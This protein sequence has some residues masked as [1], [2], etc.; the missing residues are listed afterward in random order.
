MVQEQTL[1]AAVF[2]VVLFLAY[3]STGGGDI[4]FETLGICFELHGVTAQK[5]IFFIVPAV[6]TSDP[7]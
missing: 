5:N 4:F 7:R 2:C 3:S 1:L 6:R